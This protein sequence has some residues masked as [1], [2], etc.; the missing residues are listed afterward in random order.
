MPKAL[1]N[2]RSCS[3]ASDP[4]IL[5]VAIA[6]E[7]ESQLDAAVGDEPVGVH[8]RHHAFVP[9]HASDEG[10]GHRR[11]RLGQDMIAIEIDARAGND[12]DGVPRDTEIE[13]EAAVVGVL[14]DGAAPR[15]LEEVLER[16]LNHAARERPRS[17]IVHEHRAETGQGI[18]DGDTAQAQARQ[19][20]EQDRL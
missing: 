4:G 15:P 18:D 13:E 19:G 2:S 14:H 3:G 8:Q 17:V 6:R 20:A 1:A 9:Q 11:G 16:E 10:G 12:G 7:Q 5:L